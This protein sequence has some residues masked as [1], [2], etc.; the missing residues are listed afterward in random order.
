MLELI[1]LGGFAAY[2]LA[3]T[4][5][6]TH[7]SVQGS[8]KINCY[9]IWDQITHGDG[10]QSIS[11]A[12][13][14]AG[15]LKSAYNDR[16]TTIDDLAKEM[17]AAWTGGAA[18]AAQQAGAHPLRVWMEDSGTKLADSDKYLG[19]QHNAFTTVHTQ[20]QEVPQEPPKNN[21]LNALTPWTTDT[22]RAIRDYNTKGQA[23]VDAFN[24]YF[25][26]SNDNGQNMPM[27]AI[28]QGQKESVDVKKDEK[29][30]SDKGKNGDSGG[31]SDSDGGNGKG[32]GP[33]SPGGPGN[34]NV[35]GGPGGGP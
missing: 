2:N 16:L 21:L 23:N 9:E 27:Y 8:R 22:D 3:T 20:V 14:A 32:S 35:P 10:P 24:T 13:G 26:S 33:G 12:Q 11:D 30:P 29:K 4:H 28:V 7:E 19:D 34:I 6:D 31:G 15:R 1:L 25:K 18:Q 17:D 5:S